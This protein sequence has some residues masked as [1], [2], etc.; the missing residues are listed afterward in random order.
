MTKIDMKRNCPKCKTRNTFKTLYVREIKNK[1]YFLK[2]AKFC[3]ECGYLHICEHDE[4]KVG[5]LPYA[6]KI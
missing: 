1:R 6:R 3:L 4:N 5:C 2:F